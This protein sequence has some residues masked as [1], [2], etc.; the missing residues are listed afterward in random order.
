[1]KK[2]VYELKCNLQYC[3]SKL[4]FVALVWKQTIPTERPPPAD[5]V[6][7]NFGG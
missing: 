6:S 5:E 2:F 4:S 3:M 1:M 7:A